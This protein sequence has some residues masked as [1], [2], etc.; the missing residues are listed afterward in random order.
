MVV[1]EVR[2]DQCIKLTPL[3]SPLH[4]LIGFMVIRHYEMMLGKE[5]TDLYYE[6]L[7]ND[8]SPDKLRIQV[9]QPK[10]SRG[11]VKYLML[12]LLIL[13]WLTFMYHINLSKLYCRYWEIFKTTYWK[14][15]SG[16][17]KLMQTVRIVYEIKKHWESSFICIKYSKSNTVSH[18]S[19]IAYCI[20]YI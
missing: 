3:N 10:H 5:M 12:L 11:P 16:C 17:T 6:Y 14:K 13:K 9:Q 19:F 1:Q 18:S 20:L 2:S 8:D 7:D 15:K 4:C